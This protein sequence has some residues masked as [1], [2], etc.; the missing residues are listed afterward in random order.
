MLA[1][2]GLL[3]TEAGA[4]DGPFV[5]GGWADVGVYA[6]RVCVQGDVVRWARG[7]EIGGDVGAV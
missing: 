4:V 6:L 7:W 1:I 2:A 3:L 5:L